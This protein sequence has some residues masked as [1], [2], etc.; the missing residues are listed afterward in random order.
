[1]DS[2][3]PIYQSPQRHQKTSQ[4]PLTN[5][6][7]PMKGRPAGRKDRFPRLARAAGDK[8]PGM[9][10]TPRD[11]AILETVY[12]FRVLSTPQIEALLFSTTNHTQA[13]HRLKLLFQHG[14]LHRA[15][16]MQ[17]RSENRP[18]L[19][20][21]DRKGAIE[22]AAM[23]ECE[24]KDLD[25]STQDR[26]LSSF[27]LSHLLATQDVRI[28]VMKSAGQHG[29]TV[30]EWHDEKTLRREHRS[31][32]VPITVPDGSTIQTLVIPDSYLCLEAHTRKRCFLEIDMGTMTGQ[33]SEAAP[34]SW[35]K[36]IAAYLSYYR[37]GK[38]QERYHTQ[39]LIVLSVT[40]T[41]KRLNTLKRVTEKVGGRERFWF[42]TFARLTEGDILTAPIWSV[43]TRE[44]FSPL[45]SS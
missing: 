2:L 19:Y 44:G 43:A 25:W 20:F 35:D 33:A 24:V 23:Y 38:Y 8:L 37:S 14:Y 21:L 22:L 1:M 27:H 4:I 5:L 40:T 17:Y 28:A 26:H 32:K 42:T 3:I 18:Y 41:E 7:E 12:R 15:E 10:L 16:Q 6:F 30:A 29:C 36:K 39:A 45:L 11:I 13:R 9:V 34:K 31:D